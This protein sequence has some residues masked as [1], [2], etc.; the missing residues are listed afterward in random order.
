MGFRGTSDSRNNS[1]AYYDAS[2]EQRK[3]EEAAKRSRK[4]NSICLIVIVV[5]FLGYS[6]FFQK[7]KIEAFMD[8]EA[9]GLVTLEDE[10]IAFLLT[11]VESV[12]LGDDLSTFDRGTPQSGTE[13]SSCYSGIYINDALGEYQLHVNLNVEPYVIVRY[14]DSILVFNTTTADG[15]TELYNNLLNAVNS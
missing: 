1:A 4:L 2:S 3:A 6:I 5:L 10:T 8:D 15:T 14:T 7:P 13:N 12:E 9:F 11:D